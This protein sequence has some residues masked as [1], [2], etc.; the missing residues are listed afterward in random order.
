MSPALKP[1]D[2]GDNEDQIAAVQ[3]SAAVSAAGCV[4]TG[5][6]GSIF[7]QLPLCNHGFNV[8]VFRGGGFRQ[9]NCLD[10]QPQY[11]DRFVEDLH[12]LPWE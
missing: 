9:F 7:V 8:N 2:V 3:S 6:S 10:L 11:L 1:S 4:W 12:S 5:C